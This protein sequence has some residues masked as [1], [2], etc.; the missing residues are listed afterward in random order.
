[1][2]LFICEDWIAVDVAGA[3]NGLGHVGA[4]K[5]CV[6]GME[7]HS[8]SV[9]TKPKHPCF[10]QPKSVSIELAF[11]CNYFFRHFSNLCAGEPLIGVG[12]LYL[13]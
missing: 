9:N 8:S 2:F 4:M 6:L 13:K 12:V 7:A 10:P 11:A 5:G 1:M 3:F